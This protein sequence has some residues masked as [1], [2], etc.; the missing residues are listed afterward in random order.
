MNL[1]EILL[2]SISVSLDAFAV[3]ICKGLSFKKFSLK[4]A[5]IIGL[6]FGI[7]Q[8]IMPLIGYF[9]GV[10]FNNFI[11]SF[12]HYLVFALLLFI[13]INMIIESFKKCDEKNDSIAFKS[14]I[15][16]AL[17]TSIDALAI[18]VTFA[19]LEVNLAYVFLIGL[20]TFLFSVIGVKIGNVFG[21]KYE[22][23]SKLIGGIAL[24]LIGLK[25]LLEH[26]Q[27]I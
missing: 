22:N 26:L 15:L 11:D 17:A 21:N 20:T 6:Y 25:I 4:K 3:S 23:V 27:I 19:F 24:I 13:G 12:D 10:T 14:V 7:F 16:L 2:I 18:G 9:L 5:I 1:L 8:A